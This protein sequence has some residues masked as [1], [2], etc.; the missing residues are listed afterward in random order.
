VL[1]RFGAPSA[2]ARGNASVQLERGAEAL[3]DVVRAL[4][5]EGLRVRS[6]ELHQ[7]S[8]EDVF[9]RKTGRKLETEERTSR[10]ADSLAAS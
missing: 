6:V 3:T 4:D 8:L 2:G 10:A 9:L 1:E 7:P 5:D